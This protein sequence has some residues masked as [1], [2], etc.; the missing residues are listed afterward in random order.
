M[1]KL[2]KEEQ[3]YIPQIHGHILIINVL[4]FYFICICFSLQSIKQGTLSSILVFKD[5][6]VCIKKHKQNDIN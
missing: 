3:D 1:V 5:F 2:G 4:K 6:I